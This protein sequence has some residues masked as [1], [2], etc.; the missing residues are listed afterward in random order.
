VVHAAG[1]ICCS[2]A[3]KGAKMRERNSL[4]LQVYD[5]MIEARERKARRVV[6][7]YLKRRPATSQPSD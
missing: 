4:F 6:A 7:E 1:G 5:C 2:G 3:V